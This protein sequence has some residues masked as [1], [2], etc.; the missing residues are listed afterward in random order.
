MV[1]T[2]SQ[3]IAKK[4]LSDCPVFAIRQTQVETHN[5]CLVLSGVVETYYHKQMA[6]EIVAAACREIQLFNELKVQG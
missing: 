2:E 4:A 6:Q 5:N 1:A 3:T